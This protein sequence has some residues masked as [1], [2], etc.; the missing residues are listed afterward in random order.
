[1]IIILDEVNKM[2]YLNMK[3]IQQLMNLSIIIP[4]INIMY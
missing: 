4:T 2:E 3:N 1:M